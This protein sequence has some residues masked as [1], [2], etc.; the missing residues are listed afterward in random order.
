VHKQELPYVE[1]ILSMQPIVVPLAV[2]K[3]AVSITLLGFIPVCTLLAS[4]LLR[5]SLPGFGAVISLLLA[6]VTT[7]VQAARAMHSIGEQVAADYSARPAILAST[8]ADVLAWSLLA[9]AAWIA[10]FAQLV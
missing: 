9:N 4:L 3:H 2:W 7:S 10:L 1:N 5:D 6:A 8:K